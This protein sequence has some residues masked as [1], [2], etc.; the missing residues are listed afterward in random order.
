MK[1]IIYGKKLFIADLIIT[2]VWALFAIKSSP[3]LESWMLAIIA[4]RIIM[5]FQL[6]EKSDWAG[7]CA[8]VFAG[9]CFIA[10]NYTIG[11]FGRV[12]T[13][14]MYYFAHII[15][16]N[17]AHDLFLHRYSAGFTTVHTILWIILGLWLAVLPVVVA[18]ASKNIFRFSKLG[19][20][21]IILLLAAIIAEIC[22]CKVYSVCV[23]SP[24]VVISCFLP[25]ITWLCRYG[26]RYSLVETLRQN[27]PLKLYLAF[28]SLSLVAL[29]IGLRNVYI[30][31]F[32]GLITFPA[33]FY[34]LLADS[35]GTKRI[36]TFDTVMMSVCGALYWYSMEQVM[37]V[38][39]IML[40]V[41]VII[42]IIVGVR[43]IRKTSDR[44][45]G[46]ALFVGTT[47]VLCPVLLGMNPYKV[48]EARHTHLYMKKTGAINGLYVTDNYEG[49]YGLRDRYSEILP[50]K[51]F[52]IDVI[53]PEQQ[54]ILCCE[55]VFSDNAAR[56]TFESYYTFFNL[57]DRKFIQIP[58]S[59]PIRSIKEIGKGI[60]NL[61]N[62]SDRPVFR[63]VMPG[64]GENWS[65][66]YEL[67][68]LRDYSSSREMIEDI[69]EDA[70]VSTSEDGKVKI[71]SWNTGLGGTSPDYV[72]YIQ[73]NS[74]DSVITDYFYPHSPSKYV[75]A[76]DVKDNGY[77]V[78]DGSYVRDLW[79][80]DVPHEN[81]LYIVSAYYRS[82]SIEGCSM[83]FALQFENGKLIKKQFVTDTKDLSDNVERTYY[84][85]DW[86]FLTNGLGWDWLV[87]FD[88][89]TKSLYIASH[90]DSPYMSD[91]YD[92]YHYEHG[93]FFY[94]RDDAGYWL[95]PNISSFNSLCGIYEADNKVY[96]IDST[97][98]D[99]R[100]TR[101]NK[102]ISMFER[103]ELIVTGGKEGIVENAIVFKKGNYEYIVPEYRDGYHEDYGKIVIKKNGKTIMEAKV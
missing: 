10:P 87:S 73:Y 45:V 98:C 42:V 19:R 101:W 103:P 37:T 39:I 99:Y 52:S 2:S 66:E 94:K 75:C 35:V 25:E 40:I 70:N 23:F 58:D 91:K 28:V 88:Y 57:S 38:K 90:S 68:D 86:Y 85:P 16:W 1:R 74:G 46:V 76:K 3:C 56:P 48:L 21:N 55:E 89:K 44:S 78:L 22:G 43:L 24:W 93:K 17:L 72:S 49:K 65:D 82:S 102:N 20:V 97:G 69:P 83:A 27:N 79:Q 26:K 60:Y 36:P 18:I 53:D 95:H 14:L 84:I 64:C 77:E 63:L 30:L 5:S 54:N 34:V 7:Y 31:E 32:I 67:L 4:M 62:E 50:M 80:Y 11:G 9:L 100:L 29:V 61:Y 81:P 51:Y 13:Q 59:I 6:F 92:I 96:R 41:A 33:I 12:A 47:A 8:I 71:F 15:D